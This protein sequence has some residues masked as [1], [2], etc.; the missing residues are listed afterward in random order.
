M[1]LIKVTKEGSLHFELND[2]RIGVSYASG[3][4]RVTTHKWGICNSRGG[5]LYQINPLKTEHNTRGLQG[6]RC[7]I[8]RVLLPL[9]SER[10]NLLLKFNKKN[11]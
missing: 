10:L 5:K 4:V 8:S 9:Q 3:Y 7:G 1:K 2:R 6:K 11:C